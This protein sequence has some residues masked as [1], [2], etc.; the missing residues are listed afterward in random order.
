MES[1]ASQA[2]K[3]RARYWRLVGIQPAVFGPF[4][5]LRGYETSAT[6]PDN[7]LLVSRA[8]VS[9]S[10]KWNALAWLRHLTF[11]KAL[12]HLKLLR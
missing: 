6:W 4:T 5:H 10:V 11:P 12:S 8:S 3:G 7:H 1:R 2:G 9:P